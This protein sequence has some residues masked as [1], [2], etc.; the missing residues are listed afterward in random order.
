MEGMDQ[1][2]SHELEVSFD[3]ICRRFDELYRRMVE[4]DAHAS[5]NGVMD[6][7]AAAEYIGCTPGTLR[8]WTSKRKVPF[9]KVG[10]NVR[11][12]RKDLDQWLDE[13]VVYP[14]DKPL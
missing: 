11:F 2:N 10:R 13:R 14:S 1:M 6:V 7:R 9:I 3:R 5:H 12:R 8:T 4:I